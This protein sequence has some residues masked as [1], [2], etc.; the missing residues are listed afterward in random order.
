MLLLKTMI[1]TSLFVLLVIFISIFT[2]RVV[3]FRVKNQ[4][5]QRIIRGW[6]PVILIVCILIGSFYY[7]VYYGFGH[8]ADIYRRADTAEKIVAITFDDGPSCDYTPLILDILK[9][10]N[11]PAA[12]FLVGSQVEKYPEIALRIVEE[13]H[14]VGN[15]TFDHVH[16]PTTPA[17]ELAA[18]IMRTNMEILMATGEYPHYIRPPRGFYDARFRRL[19]ELMGQEIVLWTLSSQDW[20]PGMTPDRIASRVLSLVKPGQ[21]ILFHDSGALLKNEGAS[22]LAT[23]QAL[24]IIIH[25]LLEKGFEIVSLEELLKQGVPEKDLIWDDEVT[26]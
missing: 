23:V 20:R 25:G 19:A 2:G 16:V 22:R 4:F 15:H 3:A 26:Y 8:Q 24:P 7:Y 6:L 1:L 9:E 10:Y 5:W 12:F 21:I 11:V 17:T 13:G 18:Q 14:E